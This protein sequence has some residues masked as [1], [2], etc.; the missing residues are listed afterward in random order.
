MEKDGVEVDLNAAAVAMREYAEAGLDT[1]D[2]ADHCV[3][4]AKLAFLCTC[5]DR[6][7]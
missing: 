2:M 4:H 7:T 6:L 1:F 5:A 3:S